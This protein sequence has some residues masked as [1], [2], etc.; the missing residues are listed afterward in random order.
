MVLLPLLLLLLRN[1]SRQDLWQFAGAASNADASSVFAH[2]MCTCHYVLLHHRKLLKH[3]PR[4]ASLGHCVA[5][6][7]MLPPLPLLLLLKQNIHTRHFSRHSAGASTSS[8]H[9][10]CFFR[11]R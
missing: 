2:F 4:Q 6:M 9:Y 8:Q 7:L 5:A 3:W 11:M 1:C 10:F